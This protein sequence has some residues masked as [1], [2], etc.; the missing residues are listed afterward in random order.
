MKLLIQSG[1]VTPHIF[2]TYGGVKN[3][4]LH[5]H[6]AFENFGIKIGL[7]QLPMHNHIS[8]FNS[9]TYYTFRFHSCIKFV[10]E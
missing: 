9:L 3:T 2:V 6:S 8:A 10:A 5:L 1:R 7:S 4:G